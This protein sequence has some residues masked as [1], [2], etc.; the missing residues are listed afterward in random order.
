MPQGNVLVSIFTNCHLSNLS[1]GLLI[2]P[3][4]T[5]R[6]LPG[7]PGRGASGSGLATPSYNRAFMSRAANLWMK[8]QHETSTLSSIFPGQNSDFQPSTN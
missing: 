8:G 2:P 1:N 6:L 5:T 7:R 3:L 4:C